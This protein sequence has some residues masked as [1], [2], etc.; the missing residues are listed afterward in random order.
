ML[1]I[2]IGPSKLRA[3]K[4]KRASRERGPRLS[5]R[6]APSTSQNQLMCDI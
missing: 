5:G 4:R 1:G 3:P 6:A 2:P